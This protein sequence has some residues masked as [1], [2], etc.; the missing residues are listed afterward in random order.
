MIG[1][2]TDV[3]HHGINLTEAVCN[4]CGAHMGHMFNGNLFIFKFY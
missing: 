1:H 4:K 3:G 2:N